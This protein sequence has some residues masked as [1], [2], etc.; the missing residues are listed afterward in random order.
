MR[1]SGELPPMRISNELPIP[2]ARLQRAPSPTHDF[3]GLPHEVVGEL[4]SRALLLKAADSRVQ[5]NGRKKDEGR[6]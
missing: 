2:H 4:L 6:R 3:G 5:C 1:S